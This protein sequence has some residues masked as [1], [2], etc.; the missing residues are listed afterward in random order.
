MPEFRLQFPVERVPEYAGRYSYEDDLEVVAI[1]ANTRKR[2]FYT[3]EEFKTVCTWKTKRSKPLV[4]ANTA[5][6]IE[7][8][9]RTALSD[10]DERTRVKALES[11]SGVGRPTASVFLHLAYPERYPILDRRAVQALGVDF[12]AAPSFRFWLAYV[13][14]CRRLA[15]EA[16]V[17]GRTFDQAVWQW[18]KEQGVPLY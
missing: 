2:G 14:F 9:T 16:G 10:R 18:S 4:A 6:S 1:G 3:A 7:A 12:P 5:Q 13:D 15:A 8:A 17:D 11:L